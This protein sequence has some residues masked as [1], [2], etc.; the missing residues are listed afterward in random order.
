MVALYTARR[1]PCPRQAPRGLHLVTS[2]GSLTATVNSNV[3][4]LVFLEEV[5]RMG[6]TQRVALEFLLILL[7]LPY[8]W[9]IFVV[10]ALQ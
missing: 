4:F 10:F 5:G 8:N 9:F 1:Q 2:D 3:T 7:Y 6:Q